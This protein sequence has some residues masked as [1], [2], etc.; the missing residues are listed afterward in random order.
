MSDPSP[1][2][3]YRVCPCSH[4]HHE[5]ISGAGGSPVFGVDVVMIKEKSEIARDDAAVE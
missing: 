4:L 5:V 2:Q 3:F 1:S